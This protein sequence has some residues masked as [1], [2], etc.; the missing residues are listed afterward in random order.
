[1]TIFKP[2]KIWVKT[3]DKKFFIIKHRE[4]GNNTAAKKT[5]T[6]RHRF[7]QKAPTFNFQPLIKSFET[8]K[9][10]KNGK[11]KVV[12]LV[13]KTEASGKNGQ[14]FNFFYEVSDGS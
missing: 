10:V 4:R 14:L 5:K 6:S 9:Q 2:L 12:G 7:V 3:A 13:L 8:L 1:M 11:Q